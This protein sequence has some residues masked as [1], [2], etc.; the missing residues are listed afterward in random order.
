[1]PLSLRLGV[2]AGANLVAGFLMQWY[3][4][5]RIG[6]GVRTDALFAG[7]TVPQLLVSVLAGSSMHVIVPLLSGESESRS[8]QDGWHLAFLTGAVFGV[9]AIVLGVFAP[10]WTPIVAPG[11]S[12]EARSLMVDLTRIQLVGMVF[13]ALAGVLWAVHRARQHF[14][15]AETAPL[16]GTMLGWAALIWAIPRYGVV[17]A[18]WV[19]VI[20]VGTHALLLMPGLGSYDRLPVRKDAALEAWRRLRPLMAGNAYLRTEPLIDRMLSSLGPVGDLSLYYIGQQFCAGLL[21]V[22]NNAVVA[23]MVSRLSRFVHRADWAAFARSYRRNLRGALLL[24]SAAFACAL[25]LGSVALMIVGRPD[26]ALATKALTLFWIV[27]GLG[28]SL[29]AGSAVEVVRGA[30]Y[31]TGETRVP[32][33]ADVLLFTFGIL[34]KAVSFRAFGVVGLSVAASIQMIL[35]LTLLAR[36]LNRTVSRHVV[37]A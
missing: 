17:A 18:A 22:S 20:R 14:V 6:A 25:G 19:Q 33:R 2:L 37:A 34:L 3:V 29:V 1:M 30:F 28:G 16:V 11:F 35:I 4:L 7:M 32:V 9:I 21:Q 13:T 10:Y 15:W 24:G 26:G 36:L 23:P 12:A 8:R 31:S 27:T 5:V